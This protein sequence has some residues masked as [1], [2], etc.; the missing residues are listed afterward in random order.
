MAL[1]AFAILALAF[2]LALAHSYVQWD[3][4]YVRADG[5]EVDMVMCAPNSA[6]A[7]LPLMVY[8]NGYGLW[9]S[10][11][12]YLC[13]LASEDDGYVLAL[14]EGGYPFS[15]PPDIFPFPDGSEF[16]I[17]RDQ[18]TV[19]PLIVN[20]SRTDSTSPLYGRLSGDIVTLG[21][22]MG[23]AVAVLNSDPKYA[24]DNGFEFMAP[25]ALVLHAT[26]ETGD[27]LSAA[28][29]VQIPSL[30]LIGSKDCGLNPAFQRP[31]FD[32]MAASPCRVLV[33]VTLANHCQ[34]AIYPAPRGDCSSDDGRCPPY[35]EPQDQQEWGLRLSDA[36]LAGAVKGQGY[37]ALSAILA[38]GKLDGTLDW[39]HECPDLAREL[40]Q[41]EVGV[42]FYGALE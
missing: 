22:S 18:A 38:Q 8:S 40:S 13:E 16:G 1:L 2:P 31:L 17:V 26:G 30:Q 3:A 5:R 14:Y 28:A 21:H 20:Q 35:L 6:R 34:W 42:D 10:D 39:I 12:T 23:G 24:T 27:V 9:G 15:N 37:G 33:N 4:T 32:A 7:E 36:F 41:L 29:R 25:K 11:Y 19:V